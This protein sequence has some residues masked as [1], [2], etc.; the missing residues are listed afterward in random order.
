MAHVCPYTAHLAYTSR[1]VVVDSEDS[2][3]WF[4]PLTWQQGGKWGSMFPLYTDARRDLAVGCSDD[5]FLRWFERAQGPPK[6]GDKLTVPAYR[7]LEPGAP[8][9]RAEVTVV[10]IVGG[11]IRY[12]LA[13]RM[14]A[15]SG[16]CL[17]NEDGLLVGVH[18][19]AIG[20]GTGF[21]AAVWGEWGEIPPQWR[22]EEPLGWI[23]AGLA[24]SQ[25]CALAEL[26]E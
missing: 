1:H 13:R 5:S 24:A 17:L 22:D 16:A 25:G 7:W 12:E 2:T 14:P 20:P 19:W 26:A 9:H 4:I 6:P 3:S 8:R 18:D 10:E 23:A 21:A 15:S 11:M